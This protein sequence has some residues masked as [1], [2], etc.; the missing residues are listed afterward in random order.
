MNSLRLHSTAIISFAEN[1]KDSE[2]DALLEEAKEDGC[3][4]EVASNGENYDQKIDVYLVFLARD[5]G[6]QE[7]KVKIDRRTI[8]TLHTLAIHP[9]LRK[10]CT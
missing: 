5:S 9:L 2:S 10:Y 1:K 6:L 7:I 4:Q 8:D 3:D